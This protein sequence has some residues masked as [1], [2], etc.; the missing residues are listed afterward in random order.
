M[1]QKGL[2]QG[3]GLIHCPTSVNIT[4]IRVVGKNLA[5]HM[6]IV[7]Q[8]KSK[9][10]RTTL[11]FG[12]HFFFTNYMRKHCFNHINIC[13]SQLIPITCALYRNLAT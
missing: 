3:G 9:K 1:S 4:K 2:L 6:A 11:H 7:M 10:Q 12:N 8:R 5:T 13:M